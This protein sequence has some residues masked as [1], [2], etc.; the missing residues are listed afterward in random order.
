MKYSCTEERF[1]KDIS[2]HELIIVRDNGLDKHLRFR[3]RSGCSSYWFDI[4]TYS[5][6]LIIDGDC[7]TYIFARIEDMMDFFRIKSNDWNYNKNGL[8]INP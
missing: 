7:G 4:I 6:R 1:L 5:G 3:N 8:S 2:D